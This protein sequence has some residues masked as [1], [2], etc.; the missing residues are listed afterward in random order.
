MILYQIELQSIR[1]FPS[2]H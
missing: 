2:I 1:H